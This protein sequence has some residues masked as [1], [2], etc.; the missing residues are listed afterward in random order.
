MTKF[1]I[2]GVEVEFKI[3]DKVKFRGFKRT[4]KIEFIDETRYE[5]I[6]VHW[7]QLDYEDHGTPADMGYIGRIREWINVNNLEVAQ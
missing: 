2:R 6:L 1:T 3:G 4:G 7:D 5:Q